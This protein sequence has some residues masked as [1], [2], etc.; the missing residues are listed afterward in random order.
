MKGKTA[1]KVM[2]A[3]TE[4]AKVVVIMM[5]PAV[6][7]TNARK[8]V[9]AVLMGIATVVEILMNPAA[10]EIHALIIVCAVTESA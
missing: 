3:L 1:V 6:T 7:G 2:C 5:D 9:C 10:K 8:V 4:G